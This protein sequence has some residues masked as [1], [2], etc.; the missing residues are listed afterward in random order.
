LK[1]VAEGV[2][3]REQ[4]DFLR[5]EGCDEMQGYFFSKPL[6]VEQVTALLLKGVKTRV[7]AS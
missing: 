1:V 4:L 5:K 3:T 2:E 6:P 7:P